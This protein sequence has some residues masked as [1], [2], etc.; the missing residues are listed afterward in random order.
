VPTKKILKLNTMLMGM[1]Y[2][3]QSKFHRSALNKYDTIS[4]AIV[5]KSGAIISLLRCL[6]NELR[7]IL[8]NIM[9]NNKIPKH[10]IR[11]EKILL[12]LIAEAI[13]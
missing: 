13:C 11:I 1:S 12:V 9:M 6:N 10:L 4:S 8:F 3:L 7:S 5:I 2:A